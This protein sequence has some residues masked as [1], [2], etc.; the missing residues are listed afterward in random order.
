MRK[1]VSKYS[2]LIQESLERFVSSEG[3][4]QR[5]LPIPRQIYDLLHQW[6][7]LLHT[8]VT[9]PVGASSAT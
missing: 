3:I 5:T 4:G 9:A 7:A 8:S 2:R 6:L 1:V